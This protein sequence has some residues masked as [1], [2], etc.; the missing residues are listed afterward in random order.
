VADLDST[1]RDDVAANFS[2]YGLW[3]YYDNSKWR[4]VHPF[5]AVRISSGDL[6][7]N[8]VVDL[9]IDF[10]EIYGLWALRNHAAWTPFHPFSAQGIMF[11]DVDGNGKDEVVV[12][13][14]P[15]GLWQYTNDT[16]W[17]PLHPMS[18][19]LVITG[20]FH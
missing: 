11:A 18:P 19:E 13:F 1:G 15:L 5:D 4:H 14:G 20:R 7:G 9:V 16:S 6:D 8:G 12:D 3:S 17:I 10:G 2:G